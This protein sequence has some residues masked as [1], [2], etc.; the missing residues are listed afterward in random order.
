MKLLRIIIRVG[1]AVALEMQQLPWQHLSTLLWPTTS[2]ISTCSCTTMALQ[3]QQLKATALGVEQQAPP[4]RKQVL[5]HWA[6]GEPPP[7]LHPAP[8]LQAPLWLPQGGALLLLPRQ[9]HHLLK[10]QRLVLVY[11]QEQ[12]HP[13]EVLNLC[14]TGSSA[15]SG[16]Y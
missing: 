9:P 16:P 2:A 4:Q 11:L 5:L 1:A 6:E 10:V 3:V 7:L 15:L 14:N 13:T 8:L 12:Q